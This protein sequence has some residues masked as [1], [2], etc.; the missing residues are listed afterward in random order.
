[1]A[2]IELTT[3]S[4]FTSSYSWLAPTSLGRLSAQAMANIN[5]HENSMPDIQPINNDNNEDS[6][7]ASN[8][9]NDEID[10]ENTANSSLNTKTHVYK[11]K[12]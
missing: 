11:R 12:K 6:N 10:D 3:T 8:E 9:V 7:K 5:I 2:N 1:M 4:G